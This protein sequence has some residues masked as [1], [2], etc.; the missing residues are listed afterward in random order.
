MSPFSLTINGNT[1]VLEQF[2][3]QHG[4][5]IIALHGAPGLGWR[6]EPKETFK[7]YSDTYRVIVFDMRGSGH[8]GGAGPL[9]H[10][11]WVADVE[12]IRQWAEAETFVLA[13]GSYG[14]FIA[15]EYAVLYPHRLQ[16]LVLRD[17]AATSKGIVESAIQHALSSPRVNIDLARLKSLFNGDLRDNDEFKSI[18]RDLLPLYTYKDDPGQVEEA[19]RSCM[20]RF[21]T[22]NATFKY[23]QPKYDVTGRL[24]LVEC[25]TLVTVGRV[26][27]ACTVEMSQVIVSG[28]PKAQLVVF[29]RSGHSPQ[30][31]EKELWHNIVRQFL[32]EKQ[33]KSR[34]ALA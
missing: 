14:G 33:K 7:P 19:M 22:H 17:T 1:L 31:E 21:E 13:G 26:D 8:S 34:S 30:V 11:Q 25:T 29:E 3:P 9:T 2:G 4:P 18:W 32:Q 5:V 27:W 15:L 28:L 20:F 16:A 24:H 10:A 12:S 6:D 23:E